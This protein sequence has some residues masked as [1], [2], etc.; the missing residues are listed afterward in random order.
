MSHVHCV[1]LF[2]PIQRERNKQNVNQIQQRLKMLIQKKRKR[3]ISTFLH[4]YGELIETFL[5]CLIELH[6]CWEALDEDF[7]FLYCIL[8]S[9][10]RFYPA[11]KPSLKWNKIHRINNNSLWPDATNISVLFHFHFILF[12]FFFVIAVVTVSHL[13]KILYVFY[14]RFYGSFS[15]L[16]LTI[17]LPE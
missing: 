17:L 3:E 6:V 8:T 5:L 14:S 2:Q 12:C 7:F 1:L 11:V 13:K 15:S 16:F 4:V 9:G 10:Y